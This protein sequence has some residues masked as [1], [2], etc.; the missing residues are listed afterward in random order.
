M[1]NPKAGS[2]EALEDLRPEL[3]RIGFELCPSQSPEHAGEMAAERARSG[4][5]RVV[6]A[7]GD[8]TVSAVASGLLDSGRDDLPALG[9]LPLGT[10]NDYRR[11]LGVP[12]DPAE[13]ARA[14]ATAQVRRADVIRYTLD[15]EGGRREGW[16][17]NLLSGGFGGELHE[18][19]TDEIKQRWGPLAYLRVAVA[20]A[21]DLQ[22]YACTLTLDDHPP[23]GL[24]LANLVVA[25]GRY[26]GGGF[27]AAPD[28]DPFDGT[29]NV[30]AVL[31]PRGVG[32]VVG[33]IARGLSVDLGGDYTHSDPARAWHA[34][35]LRLTA[36]PPMPITVD[37][38]KLRAESLQ[39]EV[40]PGK[41]P[42]LVPAEASGG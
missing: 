29:L 23:E 40:H 32:E 35:K 26:V 34:T 36:D 5:G 18:H 39:A 14:L 3:E 2:A 19:L 27:V 20:A 21:A 9:V 7:G 6:A 37:G 22:Q 15:G 42:V 4:V 33:L 25:N 12:D 17:V 30:V 8:G 38:E 28:A 10:G 11:S 41:L 1:F 13:A 31:P 16:C 24:A